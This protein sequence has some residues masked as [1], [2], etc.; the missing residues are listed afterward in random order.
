MDRT[1][2]RMDGGANYS[3]LCHPTRRCLPPRASTDSFDEGPCVG[4]HVNISGHDGR[5]DEVCSAKGLFATRIRWEIWNSLTRS[6]G[7]RG[8]LG[9][10]ISA[11]SRLTGRHRTR[12]CGGRD[13]KPP[14]KQPPPKPKEG[15]PPPKPLPKGKEPQPM[16]GVS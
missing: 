12:T 1:H 16:P 9:Q 15:P 6:V 14:P 10:R 7:Y 11:V 3:C 13:K 2:F 5:V 4:S 8:H